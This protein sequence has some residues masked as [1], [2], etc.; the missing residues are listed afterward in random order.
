[1]NT[2]AP[3]SAS[4]K[5]AKLTKR[6]ILL[7]ILCVL[8]FIWVVFTFPGVLSPDIKRQGAAYPPLLGLLIALQ[9]IAFVGLWHLKR[10]GVH[11]FIYVFL[12]KTILLLQLN[13]INSIGVAVSI[14]FTGLFFIWYKRLDTNL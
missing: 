2:T 12:G 9:F 14:V 1:M 3:Y 7:T 11:L 6:P 13:D 4:T 10:W 8:G 5:K